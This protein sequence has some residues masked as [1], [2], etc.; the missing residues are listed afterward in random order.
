VT[1]GSLPLTLHPPPPFPSFN[2]LKSSGL[3]Q[4]K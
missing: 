1:Q 4:P 2:R 3:S